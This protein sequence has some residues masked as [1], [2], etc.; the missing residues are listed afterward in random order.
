MSSLQSVPFF[1]SI[2]S[3][4][5]SFYS[6]LHSSLVSPSLLPAP[7]RSG[8]TWQ[9]IAKQAQDHRDASIAALDPPLPELPAE[10][11]LDVTQIPKQ[12][13]TAQEISITETTSEVLV[14]KLARGELAAVEV[15]KAFLRRAGLAQKLV[16]MLEYANFLLKHI[17][18][19]RYPSTISNTPFRTYSRET[20][21]H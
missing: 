1:P 7:R 20:T 9:E 5:H 3:L 15:T 12:I 18:K 16:G 6:R 10:L 14:D 8:P 4:L 19:S 2:L 17:R 21:E 13:L 11:P